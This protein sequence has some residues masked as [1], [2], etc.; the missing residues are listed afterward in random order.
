MAEGNNLRERALYAWRNQEE[1]ARQERLIEAAARLGAL[2]RSRLN[3]YVT[4][5]SDTVE[6]DGLTFARVI[7][8]IRSRG[9]E[10]T[11]EELNLL[12][13]CEECG[14]QVPG[15]D[16]TDLRELGRQLE[17]GMPPHRHAEHRPEGAVEG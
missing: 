7:N 16:I 9:T 14:K 5:E 3:L 12:W 2:L 4:P 8:L 10:E 17:L 13:V 1:I 11:R 15:N 6:V